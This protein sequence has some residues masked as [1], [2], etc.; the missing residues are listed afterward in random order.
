[1]PLPAVSRR[2]AVGG[3]NGIGKR[4]TARA[5]VNIRPGT[6]NIKVNGKDFV[7]YFP[8]I[9]TRGIMLEPIIATEKYNVVDINVKAWGGGFSGQAQA[10]RQALGRALISDDPENRYAV[11]EIVKTDSR[12]KERKKTGLL[13]A[14]KRPAWKRR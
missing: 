12:R 14:R 1:L 10:I 4:K 3:C 5:V 2:D 11:K 8:S 9:F 6:G 7:D 13:K